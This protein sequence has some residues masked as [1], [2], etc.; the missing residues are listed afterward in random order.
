MPFST[1]VYI[2]PT[3]IKSLKLMWM[4]CICKQRAHVY[5]EMQQ[6][7][8]CPFMGCISYHITIQ[9][10]GLHNKNIQKLNS[11]LSL[12]FFSN[13]RVKQ[14]YYLDNLNIFLPINHCRSNRSILS[15][16]NACHVSFH[17]SPFVMNTRKAGFILLASVSGRRLSR[18]A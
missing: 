15:N 7:Y 6:I 1:W 9:H 12:S 14:G 5:I 10:L 4:L 17:G 18:W 13:I 11:H 8:I 2:R 3:Q 16:I